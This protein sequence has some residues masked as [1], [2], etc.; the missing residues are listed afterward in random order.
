MGC[1]GHA[2]LPWEQEEKFESY[3]SDPGL[4]TAWGG[5]LFC[6]QDIQMGSI[7][8]RSIWVSGESAN[9]ADLGSVI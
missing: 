8:I 3:I 6:K 5:R 9:A 2:R 4:G 7:P 1:K